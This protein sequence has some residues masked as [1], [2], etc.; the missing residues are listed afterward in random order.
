MYLRQLLLFEQINTQAKYTF[1]LIPGAGGKASFVGNQHTPKPAMNRHR[2]YFFATAIWV[3]TFGNLW[4]QVDPYAPNRDP[5]DTNDPKGRKVAPNK[6]TRADDD[7]TGSSEGNRSSLRQNNRMNAQPVAAMS[8]SVGRTAELM[9]DAYTG[10]ATVFRMGIGGVYSSL[11]MVMN[12]GTYATTSATRIGGLHMNAALSLFNN[13]G[14][15]LD[16]VPY[17]DQ[18]FAAIIEGNEGSITTLGVHGLLYLAPHNE[19]SLK[20]FLQARYQS[21]SGE[22]T[23]ADFTGKVDYSVLG[24]GGGLK[25]HFISDEGDPETWLRLGVLYEKPSFQPS[26]TFSTM[27]MSLQANIASELVL[28][29]SYGQNFFIGGYTANPVNLEKVNQDFFQIR[30]IRNNLF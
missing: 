20:P 16:L 23:E 19:F 1:W 18:Q 28:D 5:T 17:L 10:R 25:V 13:R 2:L 4:A 21:I 8:Q 14:I 22:V 9:T 26:G 27:S 30:L 6:P 11:P 24:V 7:N 12:Q 15:A 29:F 3:G